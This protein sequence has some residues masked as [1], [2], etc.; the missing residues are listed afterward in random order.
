MV[1]ICQ[2][3]DCLLEDDGSS[4]GEIW[5]EVVGVNSGGILRV[6]PV[7]LRATSLRSSHGRG[8]RFESDEAKYRS[9]GEIP[10]QNDSCLKIPPVAQWLK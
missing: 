9:I 1:S 10:L 7:N 8:L 5:S 4:R 6:T 2:T 3:Q